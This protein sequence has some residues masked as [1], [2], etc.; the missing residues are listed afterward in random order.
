MLKSSCMVVFAFLFT[1]SAEASSFFVQTPT[2]VST[3]KDEVESVL[4][5]TR[6]AVGEIPGH[7]LAP[8]EGD[9]DFV[10]KTKL[11]KLGTSYSLSMEKLAKGR[12]LFVSAIRMERVE[13]LALG[14]TRLT[15]A[16]IEEKNVRADVRVTEV[17]D[18]ESTSGTK[19]RDSVRRWLF[20]FGP[21]GTVNVKNEIPCL[22]VVLGYEWEIPASNAAL[23]IVY[24]GAS[25]NFAIFGLNGE[26]FL[27]NADIS[28]YVHGTF[29]WGGFQSLNALGDSETG[30]GFGLGAGGGLRLFRTSSVNL[31]LNLGI[32]AILRS[33]GNGIP[34]TYA[35][36]VGILF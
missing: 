18:E 1:L 34:W 9:A 20:G 30:S 32:H 7:G 10:I 25:Y 17:S 23:R 4:E 15:R 26:Y 33:L 22:N 2:G 31:E 3:S 28:P 27:S 6:S 36:R 21:A 11:I 24:E 29:G 35:A 12:P 5:L 14:I 16:V 19:R 13:E 8:T